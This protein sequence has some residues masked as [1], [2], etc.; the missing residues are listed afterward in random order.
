MGAERTRIALCSHQ[1]AVHTVREWQP[2]DGYLIESRKGQ[3]RTP[4]RSGGEIAMRHLLPTRRN[5]VLK[6]SW[7]DGVRT[8]SVLE[9]QQGKAKLKLNKHANR[10]RGGGKVYSE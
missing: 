5:L 2:R 6:R 8:E 9:R 7:E 3:M 1:G 4:G 10:N